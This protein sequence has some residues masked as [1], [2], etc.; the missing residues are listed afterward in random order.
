MYKPVL[1]C[2]VCAL[3]FF[4]SVDFRVL[5]FA[6]SL[7]F[8]FF[9]GRFFVVVS[10]SVVGLRRRFLFFSKREG[11]LNTFPTE[12]SLSPRISDV[13]VV[14]VVVS[15]SSSSSSARSPSPPGTFGFGLETVPPIS[16]SLSLSL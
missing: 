3:S 10:S 6:T 1:T 15:S 16:L 4:V 2:G 5:N 9:T 11:F 8:D 12:T 14:V 13:V 7:I